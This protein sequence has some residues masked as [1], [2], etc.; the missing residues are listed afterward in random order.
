MNFTTTIIMRKI[1]HIT[2]LVLMTLSFVVKFLS[3]QPNPLAVNEISIQV[4]KGLHGDPAQVV[5]AKPALA[6][7]AAQNC[8][9]NWILG[10]VFERL[11]DQNA[12]LAV[13]QRLLD[14]SK[15]D[16]NLLVLKNADNE[17][18]TRLIVQH[19]P[20][21]PDALFSLAMIILKKNPAEAVGLFEQVVAYR[22]QDGYSWCRLG[23]LYENGKQFEKAANAFLNCCQNG[24]PGSHGCW[25]AGRMMEKLGNPLKAI[26]YYRLSQWET[27]LKRADELEKQIQ[28]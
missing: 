2:L 22:P 12:K 20:S 14:C 11:G 4:M 28:P 23:Y 25:G 6:E 26:E 3:D 9:A 16:I 27:A 13:W 10:L 8:R 17:Q 21:D 18:F 7:M 19:Y 1:F 15:A 24:D 5:K